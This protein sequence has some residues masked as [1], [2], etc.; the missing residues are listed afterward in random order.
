MKEEHC[1]QSEGI[2]ESK[3][4]KSERTWHQELGIRPMRPEQRDL[5]K[6][7]SCGLQNKSLISDFVHRAVHC[8]QLQEPPGGPGG[9]LC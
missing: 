9:R 6:A 5:G 2:F 8:E 1:C 4:L 3:V 7:L